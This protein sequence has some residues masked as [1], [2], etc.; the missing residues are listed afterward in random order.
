MTPGVHRTSETALAER[1]RPDGDTSPD[2]PGDPDF[3]DPSVRNSKLSDTC[4]RPVYITDS[5]I[6]HL[7]SRRVI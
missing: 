4:A 3:G 5:A 6:R 1:P 7:A 2:L